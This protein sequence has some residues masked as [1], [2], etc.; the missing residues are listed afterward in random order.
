RAGRRDAQG[1]RHDQ[2]ARE[3]P[4]P[5][6]ATASAVPAEVAHAFHRM[7]LWAPDP[8][9]QGVRLSRAA[10]AASSSLGP[11]LDA[12]SDVPRPSLA[13]ARLSLTGPSTLATQAVIAAA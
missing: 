2:R 13:G 7:L 8:P 6:P 11:V 9:A 3:R 12:S 10:R 5:H 1:T 4:D